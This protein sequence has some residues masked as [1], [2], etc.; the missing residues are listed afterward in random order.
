[1]KSRASKFHSQVLRAVAHRAAADPM[2]KVKKMIKD[3]VTK[4]LEEANEEADHKGYCDTELTTNAQTRS[5]KSDAVQTL[6]AEQEG[7]DASI[8]KLGESITALTHQVSE[9]EA[10]ASKATSLRTAEKKANTDTVEDAKQAQAAVAQALTV[11]REFYGKAAESFLQIAEP[12]QGMQGE[13]GGVIGMLE[14][15]ESDFARLESQTA[16]AEATGQKEYD[17]FMTDTKI[18]KASKQADIDH[19]TAKKQ[20]EEQTLVNTKKDLEGSQGELDA[21]LTYFEK[22]KPSC[23]DSGV[24]YED[25]VARRKEEI[26]S[27]QEALQIMNGEEIA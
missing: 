15:I 19:K 2:A 4:L 8:S 6:T 27:M 7:L 12:Y 26:A 25:R 5:E 18:D 17:G 11:L 14:V 3:L 23:V 9:L 22:L 1:L 16:S 10:A 24:S 20:D 13:S 21:A